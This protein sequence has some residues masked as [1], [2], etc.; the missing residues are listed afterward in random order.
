MWAH[1]HLNTCMPRQK[2]VT[3]THT[4]PNAHV[5]VQ[6]HTCT[7]LGKNYEKSVH[8][9]QFLLRKKIQKILLTFDFCFQK[10]NIFIIL[11]LTKFCK[12]IRNTRYGLVSKELNLIKTCTFGTIFYFQAKYY[13]LILSFRCTHIVFNDL[14]NFVS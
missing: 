9:S 1:I 11:I 2:T 8:N 6:S 10:K 7:H 3:L 12:E 14:E 4:V 13:L 5:Q